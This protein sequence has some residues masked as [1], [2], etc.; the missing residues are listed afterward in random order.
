MTYQNAV[1]N[2]MVTYGKYGITKESIKEQL[3]SGI[4]ENGFSVNAA[5]NGIRMVL[6][7]LFNERE[8]FSVEDIVEITGESRETIVQTIEDMRQQA[9][10]NGENPDD[11]ATEVHKEDR[12]I[13]YFPNGLKS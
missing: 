6:G 4:M 8:Y 11:Y 13:L 7:G 10:D 1:N 9:I 5:Y 12:T 2:L 3:N